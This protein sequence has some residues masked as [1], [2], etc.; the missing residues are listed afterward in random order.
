MAFGPRR[1]IMV[2]GINKITRNIDTAFKR[3]RTVAAP[4]NARR[5]GWADIP[6]YDGECDDCA[7]G[8]RQCNSSLITHYS[9][10]PERVSV[11]LVNKDLGF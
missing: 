1:L 11:V 6:C 7:S 9:R 5:H 10:D 3:I 8:H 2:A 4:M